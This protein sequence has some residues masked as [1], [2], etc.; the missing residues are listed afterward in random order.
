[1][2][3]SWEEMRSLGAASLRVGFMYGP[4]SLSVF[5]ISQPVTPHTLAW[6]LPWATGGSVTQALAFQPPAQA[7]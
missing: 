5:S 7:A 1:M 3:L 4:D 2:Q 6:V